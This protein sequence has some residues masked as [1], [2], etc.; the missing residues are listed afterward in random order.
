MPT[1]SEFGFP[2]FDTGSWH[3]LMVPSGTPKAIIDRIPAEVARAVQD[4][5]FAA[6]MTTLGVD[7]LGNSPQD[8]TKMISA[9]IELW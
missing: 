4:P 3:G 1:V 9:D 6:R 2:G 8:F 5:E 7:P